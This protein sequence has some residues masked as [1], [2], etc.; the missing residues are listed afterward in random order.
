VLLAWASLAWAV[1]VCS[2]APGTHR[3]TYSGTHTHTQVHTL[4]APQVRRSTYHD[5]VKLAELSRHLDVAG[6]QTYVI[7]A[8]R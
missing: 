7:N 2:F 3:H 5:V 1:A 8:G 6:I 4:L